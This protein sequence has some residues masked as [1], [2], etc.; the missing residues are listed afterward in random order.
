MN[1][2]LKTLNTTLH[3]TIQEIDDSNKEGEH[4]FN[5]HQE[6]YAKLAYNHEYLSRKH[7]SK[8]KRCSKYKRNIVALQEDVVAANKK[9][10]VTGAQLD[11]S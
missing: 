3:E 2:E 5:M 4:S 8:K 11:K 10:T 1:K 7:E 6:K 9:L